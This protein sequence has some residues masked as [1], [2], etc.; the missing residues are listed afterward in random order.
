MFSICLIKINV[1]RVKTMAKVGGTPSADAVEDHSPGAEITPNTADGHKISA[2]AVGDVPHGA[3]D[4]PVSSVA[5]P[6]TVEIPEVGVTPVNLRAGPY[7]VE[8]STWGTNADAGNG[9]VHYLGT[10]FF[11][12][13][14]GHA[15]ITMKVPATPEYR[16]L[17]EKYCD[18]DDIERPEIPYRLVTK[19]VKQ[20]QRNEDGS[21][22]ASEANAYTES[23][24]EVY[25][26]WWPGKENNHDAF[27]IFRQEAPDAE[28]DNKS[29]FVLVDSV[30]TDRVAERD[31]VHFPVSA[32][33]AEH[34]N[35]EQRVQRGKMGGRVVT[36]APQAIIHQM[37]LSDEDMHKF[38]VESS[39]GLFRAQQASLDVLFAKLHGHGYLSDTEKNNCIEAEELL[40]VLSTPSTPSYDLTKKNDDG[41]DFV[42]IIKD[43]LGTL[44]PGWEDNIENM[45]AVTQEE[46]DLLLEEIK[47]VIELSPNLRKAKIGET[48]K[49]LLNRFLISSDFNWREHV[50]NQDQI[51][52]AECLLLKS[53]ATKVSS[54]VNEKLTSQVQALEEI[55][56]A[57]I[58]EKKKMLKLASK[59]FNL[60]EQVNNI[61]RLKENLLTEEDIELLNG[62]IADLLGS[63]WPDRAM[64]DIKSEIVGN[65]ENLN[66]QIEG[67]KEQVS[68]YDYKKAQIDYLQTRQKTKNNIIRKIQKA[69]G[70]SIDSDED[71]E[72]E[73]EEEE[74][75]HIPVEL[76]GSWQ[77]EGIVQKSLNLEE[78]I[79]SLAEMSESLSSL[80]EII[81][82]HN[83]YSVAEKDKAQDALDIL[84]VF[85]DREPPI[86]M[87]YNQKEV[88]AFCDILDEID[89]GWDYEGTSADGGEITS[90][91]F[92]ILK[93]K[94]LHIIEVEPSADDLKVLP[95]EISYLD[96]LFP[97]DVGGW[98]EELSNSLNL[99]AAGVN[100]LRNK[101]NTE[102]GM[103]DANILSNIENK[104]KIKR[105][106]NK[107]KQKTIDF[108][109]Q[110]V[111]NECALYEELNDIR[112]II[113]ILNADGDVSLSKS[114]IKIVQPHIPK[115]ARL[116]LAPGDKIV[117]GDLDIIKGKMIDRVNS[118]EDALVHIHDDVPMHVY[119]KV[120]YR[121]ASDTKKLDKAILMLE[122]IL[123]ESSGKLE[124]IV[125]GRG[126]KRIEYKILPI[127]T[128]QAKGSKNKKN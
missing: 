124:N 87:K 127:N 2:S 74:V 117:G 116:M 25:W 42:D 18:G 83:A 14:V 104:K 41:I 85:A 12:G 112:K 17:L 7:G 38:Q 128:L 50:K 37:N 29:S 11:G 78:Q 100:I 97:S 56:Q 47:L 86:R 98:R 4:S 40:N 108:S 6:N 55:E 107:M 32:K 68:A 123:E 91:K 125:K 59:Y 48:E 46:M 109:R 36:L 113:S 10:E 89:D 30:T 52:E 45:E 102:A 21:F 95:D 75:I 51:T 118:I 54:K 35:L 60:K 103:N 1:I 71:E 76:S 5:T 13:N 69:K 114:H 34:F 43:K 61:T 19:D 22:S 15:S 23:Y 65:L 106:I 81:V 67:L 119:H 121:E 96:R 49:M 120:K 94:I 57:Q 111:R 28:A 82:K 92:D 3:I 77:L 9:M 33:V 105:Q 64:L 63:E 39:K 88:K 122:N 24:Y 99:K 93:G 110:V 126:D 90:E 72:E 80:K 53:K 79:S 31:G 66:M 62:Q 70:V 115:S 20:S 84:S 73:E 44:L 16:D 8:V 27:A 101:V 58:E 26:S